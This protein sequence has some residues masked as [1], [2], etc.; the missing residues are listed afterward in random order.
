VYS[1]LHSEKI[2][3]PALKLDEF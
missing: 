3:S 2:E 1:H